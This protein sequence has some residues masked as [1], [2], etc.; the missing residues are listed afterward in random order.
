MFHVLVHIIFSREHW[1]RIA[2]TNPLERLNGEV[3]RRP[4]VVGLKTAR[5]Q[6]P[7]DRAV[8]RPVGALIL[9]QN[10]EGGAVSPRSISLESL[11]TL[12]DDPVLRL[13]AVVA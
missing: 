3:K 12:R 9:Q 10:D 13:A 8:V 7:N 4:D 1:S 11:G 6:V 5:F 2:Y